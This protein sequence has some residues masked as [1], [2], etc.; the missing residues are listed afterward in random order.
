MSTL[1]T[2]DALATW[3]AHLEASDQF[4]DAAADWSGTLL[5]LEG[6]ADAHER[7]T[8][9]RIDG[10]T[11]PELRL[12]TTTDLAHAD[13]V[14]AASPTTWGDLVAARTT[15]M[16]AALTGRL[17]LVRGD[18]LSLLPH[19]KAAAALLAAAHSGGA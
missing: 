19:A 18:V 7:S 2:S 4:R 10:G 9:V 6:T 14:L 8:W 5:L 15:P 12:G 13:F 11:C 16:T 3:R 17:Q 1:F